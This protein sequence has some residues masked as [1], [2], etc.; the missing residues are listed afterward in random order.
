[1]FVRLCHD[2]VQP[3]LVKNAQR[4]EAVRSH[5]DEADFSAAWQIGRRTPILH[6]VDAA[7]SDELPQLT[8]DDGAVSDPRFGL[9]P[10]EREV[11][12]LLR[13]GLSNREIGEQLFI[14]ERT[15]QTHVQHILD[16]L[17]VSTRAAAAVIAVEKQLL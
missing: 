11:L 7:V 2:G 1:M 5:L 16:K 10:R 15:A 6:T 4:L 17:N 12:A 13:D 9:T 3:R 8:P 14:S